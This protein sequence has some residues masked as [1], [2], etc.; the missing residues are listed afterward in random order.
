MPPKYLVDNMENFIAQGNLPSLKNIIKE[1]RSECAGLVLQKEKAKTAQF[2]KDAR[3][4]MI[5]LSQLLVTSLVSQIEKDN[6][7]KP[8]VVSQD[9]S[10]ATRPVWCAGML[11]L[12][13]AGSSCCQDK[14]TPGCH[15]V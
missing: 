3:Q 9:G 12:F 14:T 13:G 5:N 10:I 7:L 15:G 2:K 4:R 1:F 11:E 8:A 6:A